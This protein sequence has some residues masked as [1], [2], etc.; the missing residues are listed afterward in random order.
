MGCLGDL[1]SKRVACREALVGVRGGAPSSS[2]MV[3]GGVTGDISNS[4]FKNKDKLK[5]KNVLLVTLLSKGGWLDS[6][7]LNLIN[8]IRNFRG[9]SKICKVSPIDINGLDYSIQSYSSTC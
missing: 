5:K 3:R 6:L 1:G 4:T 2:P 7:T 9:F 8:E